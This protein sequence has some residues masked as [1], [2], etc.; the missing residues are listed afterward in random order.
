MFVFLRKIFFCSNNNISGQ[1]SV[2][3]ELLD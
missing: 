1:V 2:R 3:E